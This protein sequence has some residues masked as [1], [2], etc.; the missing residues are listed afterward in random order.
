MP[1]LCT[2][3]S[4]PGP[5]GPQGPPGVGINMKGT[6]ATAA[7]L[8][9][10]GNQ[11]NDCYTALD[12][13]HGWVWNGTAWIDVGPIQ[14]PQGNPG[15][16]GTA[17]TITVGTTTTGAPGTQASVVNAG[18]SS[19]AVLDFT[20]PTGATGATGATGS[21]GAQGAT[22]PTGPTGAT[23]SQGPTGATGATGPQGQ[24][25][26]WRGTWSASTA[27]NPY[28]VVDRAGSSYVCTV[29]STGFDPATDTS[30]WNLM[31]QEG[32]TGP[33][34]SQGPP[35]DTGATG[36]TGP[37]GAT[38]ATG[39]QGPAATV[40][41]GTTT[42]GAPGTNAAV[43]NT[44]STSAAVFNFTIPAGATGATG[45]QGATGATGPTG[46]TGATGAQGPPGPDVVST[47]PGNIAT[48]GTDGYILVPQLTLWY[49]R[50][51]SFNAIGNPTFEVDQANVTNA[52]INPANNIR[53][54]D[55]W[56]TGKGASVTGAVNT[57]A[58]AGVSIK[59]PGTSYCISRS[60]LSLTVSTAQASLA[61]G[62]Y[63][64]IYQ[65]VEGP[66]FRELSADVN[67]I[68]LLVYSTIAPL[69]FAVTLRDSPVTKSLV[70]L[71]TIPTANTWTLLTLP[72]LPAFPSGNFTTAPGSAGYLLAIC[73]ACGTTNQAPA[74]G[75]W[76]SGAFFGA[77]GMTNWLATS[78]NVFYCAFVQ[79]EPGSQC[80][81]LIDKPFTQNLD[82]C[83]RYYIKSYPY[84]NAP[85]TATSNGCLTQNSS[86]VANWAYVIQTVRY[87][88]VM[89]KN[90]T[91]TIYSTDGTINAV[92]D[93][94]NGVNRTVAGLLVPSGDAGYG[95]ISLSAAAS[96]GN[97]WYS[98]QH[99]ADTGW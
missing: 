92:A 48:L 37:Q 9:T 22:G 42:T 58:G 88:K 64:I 55:R 7:D 90:V 36:A 10:S 53:I 83:L 14:G 32:A 15:P 6:V 31:A 99:V 5:V 1:V 25:F 67:S 76:Q 61:A 78:G 87:P 98:W 57:Q 82:E 81:T 79:H 95:G 17:A 89:A 80:T 8:P 27:Y 30:H 56:F 2:P 94:T 47:D 54:A 73:L 11:A 20:I 86:A 33:T 24:G 21:Q 71:L 12:T 51:R 52:L 96:T 65:N 59:V 26:T 91:P 23:G 84:A 69:T 4:I 3:P 41:V 19:A 70:N 18:S 66:Y 40:T 16:A 85:G 50:L 75:T 49:Q 44:G 38:G 97:P 72:N 77:A 46:P 74:T 35:G 60:Q 45:P 43:T 93:R 13:G 63:Y 68:S 34:G 39:A 29:A 28:D 62:D